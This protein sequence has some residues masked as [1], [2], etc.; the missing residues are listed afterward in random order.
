MIFKR[1]VSEA[2][3]VN[4]SLA[5]FSSICAQSAEGTKSLSEQKGLHQNDASPFVSLCR[6]ECDYADC[7]EQETMR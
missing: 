3:V 4:C 7:S 5:A 1:A 6:R 2:S